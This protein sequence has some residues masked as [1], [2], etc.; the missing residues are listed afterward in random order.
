MVDLE[1]ERRRPS[2]FQLSSLSLDTLTP[3]NPI[4][5]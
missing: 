3:A 1:F 4:V 2:D 5:C